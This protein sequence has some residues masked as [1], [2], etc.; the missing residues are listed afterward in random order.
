MSKDRRR[1]EQ[2]GLIFR[3]GNLVDQKQ[4]LAEHPTKTQQEAEKQAMKEA[5]NSFK[6]V[7]D[8][9]D[10]SAILAES[11]PY[12]CSKCGITHR[13]GKVFVEHHKYAVEV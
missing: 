12:F 10:V 3:D 2:T 6:A 9:K 1:F 7:T 11:E 4:W 5:L 8:P 13:R